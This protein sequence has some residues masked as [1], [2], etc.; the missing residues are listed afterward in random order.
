[1]VQSQKV[2]LGNTPIDYRAH[3]GKNFK[4][5]NL[6]TLGAKPPLRHI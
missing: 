2:Y 4:K 5:L 3:P 6:G 1:M